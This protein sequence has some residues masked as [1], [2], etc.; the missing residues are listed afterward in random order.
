MFDLTKVKTH[1]D[2]FGYM[3]DDDFMEK[4]KGSKTRECK[5]VYFNEHIYIVASLTEAEVAGF[6]GHMYFRESN[7]NREIYKFIEDSGWG[8]YGK[9]NNGEKAHFSRGC[10]MAILA[11]TDPKVEGMKIPAGFLKT[12]EDKKRDV[13]MVNVS[14]SQDNLEIHK[15]DIMPHSV[16]YC[17]EKYIEGYVKPHHDLDQ[18]FLYADFIQAYIFGAEFGKDRN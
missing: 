15:I 13:D 10:S 18:P 1:I 16:L 5:V 6:F 2:K 12:Y 7:G 11:T 9:N 14:Y 8:L 4:M 17:A 3:Y